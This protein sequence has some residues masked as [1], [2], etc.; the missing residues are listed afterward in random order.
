[1]SHYQRVT[2]GN[3]CPVCG[4]GRWCYVYED[5]GDVVCMRV[6]SEEP[7]PSGSGWI[8]R[9]EGGLP[10]IKVQPEVREAK[11]L[12]LKT[13]DR[14]YRA[15]VAALPLSEKHRE[16]LEGPKRGIKRKDLEVLAYGTLPGDWE[17]QSKAL[18][19]MRK[20]IGRDTLAG[21]PGVYSD[22]MG[23]RLINVSGILLPS[24]SAHGLIQGF[25]I[26]RDGENPDPRYLW[27][28]SGGR[29]GGTNCGAPV[30]LA[31][32]RFSE[33]ALWITEGV[34]KAD[35]VSLQ[36]QARVLGL[37]GVMMWRRAADMIRLLKPVDVVIAYDMDLYEK[38][39]VAYA[40]RHLTHL[41]QADFPD[42]HLY[43]ATWSHEKGLDDAL[44]ADETIS[45]RRWRD[46]LLPDSSTTATAV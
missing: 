32:R 4:K 44:L 24:R 37:P 17:P 25:Q 6:S 1:M 45:L 29:E 10:Q 13:L 26:R 28:S 33:R 39:E 46:D 16:H 12:D 20:A 40:F 35:I 5:T 34:L 3:P 19:A 36:L 14:A 41:L 15:F 30:H 11:K 42:V 22:Q 23:Q 18:A 9:K 38:V 8:H 43:H 27:L 21:V 7:H 2:P 31:G